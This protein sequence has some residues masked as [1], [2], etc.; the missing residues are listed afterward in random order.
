MK[1]AL[2][3]SIAVL[4]ALVA[5]PAWAGA[6]LYDRV[7]LVVALKGWPPCCVVDGRS[8][9][10]RDKQPLPGAVVWS[11]DLR[12]EPTGAVVVVADADAAALSIARKI[13]RR[14]RA[15]EVLAVKGGYATWNA[16][17]SAASGSRMPSTFVIPS[18]TCEQG[19]PLQTLRSDPR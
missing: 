1:R 10:E 14:F 4:A 5:L 2:L 17:V 15:K 12:I 19:K 16:L 18:N 6:S 3:G 13:E 8:Q 11:K 7:Q 9:A